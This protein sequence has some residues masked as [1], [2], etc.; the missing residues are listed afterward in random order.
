MTYIVFDIIICPISQVINTLPIDTQIRRFIKNG[1]LYKTRKTWESQLLAYPT[2][3]LSHLPCL[4][5]SN[6]S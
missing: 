5:I 6:S 3:G 4:R 1:S 2:H